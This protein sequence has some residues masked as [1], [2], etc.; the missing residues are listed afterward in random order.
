MCIRDSLVNDQTFLNTKTKGK[1]SYE[2][3]TEWD[4]IMSSCRKNSSAFKVI[5]VTQDT[6]FT[7]KTAIESY[8]KKSN[9][10]ALKL[11]KKNV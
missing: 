1:A 11:K 7:F 8:F 9:Q 5:K 6:M 4:N 10:P 3:E 2:M